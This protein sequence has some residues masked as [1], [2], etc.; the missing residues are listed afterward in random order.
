MLG[1]I[2][3]NKS[4]G[5][6]WIVKFQGV[7]RR[8]RDLGEAERFLTGLRF[9][10]DQ[11]TFDPRD[12]QKNQP[13][14]FSHQATQ[15]LKYKEREVRCM[16]NLRYHA[17]HAMEYFKDSNVKLINYGNL[18]DFLHSLPE[19]LSGKTRHNIMTS[20]HSFYTWLHD[21]EGIE[22]PKFP[23]VKFDLAYRKIVDKET[24]AA[25]LEEIRRI[26][27]DVNPKIWLGVKWL[28]TYISI[29]PI[30]LTH[31]LE[32]DIDLKTGLMVIQHGKTGQKV[33]PL[34][35][36]DVDLIQ[37]LPRG[38]PHLYFFRHGKRKG[39]QEHRRHKF[40]KDY[41]Y[42]W[43]KQ[44]CANLGIEGVDLYGGTRHSSAVALRTM[45]SPE[46][47]RRATMHSTNAA[48]ER[49]FRVEHAELREIYAETRLKLNNGGA[50]ESK[51]L[52]FQRKTS[53]EGGT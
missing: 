4:Q 13:L 12:W 34:L 31:V 17:G 26:S 37:S 19:H 44:A 48:F 46:A 53:A 28:A 3:P 18:E 47:I 15:W 8:F 42:T 16:K 49:Y 14:S 25:I 41:F 1:G 29:R 52:E 40:G 22:I 50:T 36:E 2:Y 9:S 38:M 7:Y 39:L 32:S 35:D 20:L 6:P 21:R 43:W 30:E 11:G 24:Q 27:W 10:H 33:I 51:L 5:S 45:R 23:T